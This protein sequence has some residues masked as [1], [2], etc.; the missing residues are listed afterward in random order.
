VKGIRCCVCSEPYTAR[1]SRMHNDSNMIAFGARVVGPDMAKMIVDEWLNAD[2]QGGRHQVRVDMIT[3]IEQTQSL[4]SYQL[5]FLRA[6]LYGVNNGFNEKEVRES[7]NL[8]VP[9]NVD[10][11]KKSLVEKE[12]IEYT[13]KGVE[14]GDPVLR[15]WLKRILF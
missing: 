8:G 1:L 4:T 13:E 6:I 12:L 2:F 10:R 14:I 5:N 3:E 9:S 15:L 7:F 11:L